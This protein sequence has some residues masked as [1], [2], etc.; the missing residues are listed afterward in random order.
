M[1]RKHNVSSLSKH[2][3][4]SEHGSGETTSRKSIETIVIRKHK[5]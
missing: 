4:A 5:L 3:R 1:E 2:I